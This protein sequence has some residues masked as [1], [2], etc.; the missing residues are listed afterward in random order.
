MRY[1]FIVNP[2][3][4]NGSFLKKKTDEKIKDIAEKNKVI[5][6]IRYTEKKGDAY[7]IIKSC[8]C[9]YPCE[10]LAFFACGGDG[11]LYEAVLKTEEET[12]RYYVAPEKK[13][14][15]A[16]KYKNEN[17]GFFAVVLGVCIL[18]AVGVLFTVL[19]PVLSDFLDSLFSA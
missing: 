1:I 17:V 3:A 10:E 5:A 18:V 9:E 16:A 6:E 13:K 7:N 11:T 14:M 19:Y 12:P 15:L 4:G 8:V 2:A